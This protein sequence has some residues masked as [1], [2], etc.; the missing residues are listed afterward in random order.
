MAVT[1][2]NILEKFKTDINNFMSTV[3]PKIDV[4]LLSRY[5]SISTY[6]YIKIEEETIARFAYG[7][8]YIRVKEHVKKVL[9]DELNYI[10][11]DW[12]VVEGVKGSYLFHTPENL[13][14]RLKNRKKKNNNDVSRKIEEDIDRYDLM[15]VEEPDA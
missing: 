1:P 3:E 13:L 7:Q 8:G 11:K 5:T 15:D 10:Y 2:D 14:A 4:Y 12:T 6:G 9:V